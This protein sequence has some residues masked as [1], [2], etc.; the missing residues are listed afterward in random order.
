MRNRKDEYVVPFKT[1]VDYFKQVLDGKYENVNIFKRLLEDKGWEGYDNDLHV[2]PF[3]KAV[4]GMLSVGCPNSCPFCPTALTHK[5]NIY[6]GDPNFIIPQ[7][8]NMKVHFMDENFFSND[9]K[10]VLPL[11]KEHNVEWLAMS[12]YRSTVRALKIHGEKYLYKCGLRVIEMGLENVVLYRKAQAPIETKDIVIYYLN[13]TC[14]PGETK[15]SIKQNAEW[16][17]KNSL[18]RPIHFN[19]SLWYAPGQF[20]HPYENKG[21]KDG[22]WLDGAYARTRPSWMPISLLREEY[23]IVDLELAN[24]YGQM[25]YGNKIYTPKKA[26]TIGHFIQGCQQR[27]AW[28]LTGIRCGAIT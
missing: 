16:M 8:A 20:Y 2:Y 22:Q 15:Y 21:A 23:R 10:V 14:L 7:Y 4:P 5:R 13:M 26:G 18:A 1:P 9:M 28:L 3:N 19:N 27:A 25:V 11:L 24:Y 12:D 6:F 17:K